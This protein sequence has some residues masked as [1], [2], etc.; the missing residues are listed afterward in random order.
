MRN[1]TA[2]GNMQKHSWSE[3]FIL[4]WKAHLIAFIALSNFELWKKG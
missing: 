2:F 4:R 1:V 3:H